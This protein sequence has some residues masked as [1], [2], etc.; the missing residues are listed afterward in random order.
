MENAEINDD[1]LGNDFQ[2]LIV[3][4]CKLLTSSVLKTNRIRLATTDGFSA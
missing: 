1:P 3:I 4:I 2:T